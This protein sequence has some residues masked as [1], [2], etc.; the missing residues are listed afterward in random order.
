M[1]LRTSL[2]LVAVAGILAF[3]SCS[4]NVQES[5]EYRSLQQRTDSLQQQV[6]AKEQEVED[7]AATVNEI[8]NNLTAIDK[9]QLSIT[10]LKK[11]GQEANQKDRI[12]EMIAGI[13]NY[14][15]QN[16]Q[17]MEKL[18]SQV[19][20]GGKR[21]AALQ[22]LV[23]S[24]RA[25][26]AA[27]EAEITELRSTID[28]LTTENTGLK[29]QVAD[30]DRSLSSRDSTLAMRQKDI[31]ERDTEIYT[32]YYIHGKKSDLEKAGVIDRKGGVLG[33]GKTSEVSGRIDKTKLT[34]ID[35]RNQD[36]V[37]LGITSRKNVI[38]SHPSDSYYITKVGD[39]THLKITDFKKFWSLTKYLV[40][41]TN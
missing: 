32:A 16:R 25:S 1:N 28:G 5:P 37:N 6:S 10:T 8:E 14:M 11:E 36:D 35:M 24:L 26:I 23:T 30:R 41:E 13:D 40:I 39:E 33:L 17:R 3:S 19:K 22:R 27:K 20:K 4:T 29:G 9:D 15:E 18:E 2:P 7:V 34:A 31:Q 12:N 21:V 38:S